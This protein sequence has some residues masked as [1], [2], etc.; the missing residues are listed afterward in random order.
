MKKILAVLLC[1][2]IICASAFA[3]SFLFSIEPLD[4]AGIVKLSDEQLIDTY[5]NVLVEVEALKTFYAKGGLIPK[6]YAK[7]KETIKYKIL[8]VQEI[9]KRKLEVP[10]SE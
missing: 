2:L 5:I 7:F 10:R 1:A 6:E 4:K 8:L 3:Q 9:N